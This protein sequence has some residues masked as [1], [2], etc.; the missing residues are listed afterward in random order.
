MSARHRYQSLM[1]SAQGRAGEDLVAATRDLRTDDPTPHPLATE[2]SRNKVP[3][4]DSCSKAGADARPSHSTEAT[5]SGVT[6]GTGS[7]RQSSSG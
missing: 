3:K 4:A 1:A 6:R 2:T 5:T 7:S